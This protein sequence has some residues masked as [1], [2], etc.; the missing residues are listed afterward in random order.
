MSRICNS[1]GTEN[2]DEYNFCKRCGNS[3]DEKQPVN[4]FIPNTS[5]S[6]AP[7]LPEIDGVSYKEMSVFV[8]KNSYKIMDKFSKMKLADS[9][10]SW[11]WP[12]AVLS[13][14]FGFFGAA[15]W[16]F[17][18]KMN[19]VALI[20]VALGLVF[21]II[22]MGLTFNMMVDVIDNTYTAIQEFTENKDFL[23]FYSSVFDMATETSQNTNTALVNLFND[24]EMGLSTIG[25]G[26][27]S[28]YLYKQFAVKKIKNTKEAEFDENT[29]YY[30]L[31]ARGGTSSG[32]AAVGVV[33]MII[34]GGIINTIPQIA[35]FL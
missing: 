5:Y 3:L 14:F 18:R 10:I 34:A 27:F 6:S 19:K 20:L 30:A 13:F 7:V 32:M 33:I 16:F 9:K 12:V 22:G 8:G 23:S 26:M 15:F 17:Y 24:I 31:S 1:C 2:N 25:M 35:Y 21:D 28:F 4:N 11:C 29:Y